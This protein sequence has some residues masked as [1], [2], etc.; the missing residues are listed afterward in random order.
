LNVS[1]LPISLSSFNGILLEDQ[2]AVLLK[3]VTISEKNNDY[4]TLWKSTN[5][6]DWNVI[7][8]VQG[9]GT[10]DLLLEYFYVD[11]ILVS[12]IN[13]YNLSQT[14]YNGHT[15][16]FGIIAI[17]TKNLIDRH[18]IKQRFNLLGQ[19]VDDNFNGPHILVW[20]NG[21][22]EVRIN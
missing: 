20:D 22:V 11:R 16:F 4:F 19:P 9:A 2:I 18:Y 7:A 17:D 8:I 12:G 6:Y 10:S 14:D 15:N 21:D 1:P 13:Y 3:W 5:G